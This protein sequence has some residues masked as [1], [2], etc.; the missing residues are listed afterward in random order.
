[1][2]RGESVRARMARAVL[3]LFGWTVVQE[4]PPEDRYV[5]VV[6]PHTSNWDFP[7]GI[8]AREAMELDARWVGKKALFRFPFGPIMRAL[9]GVSVDRSRS[10]NFVEQVVER[11]RREEEFVL[12]ITPEGT[13]SRME[14]W[15]T[16]FYYIALE[17]EVPVALAF[18]DFGRKRVGVGGWIRPTGDLEADMERIRDFYQGMEAKRPELMGP[19]RTTAPERDDAAARGEEPAG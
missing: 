12:V 14:R 6:A 4:L 7:V 11:M 18:L 5:V 9:G 8:L 1:M 15:R 19:V 16:G 13:R 10:Q 2:S 17:A 3:R